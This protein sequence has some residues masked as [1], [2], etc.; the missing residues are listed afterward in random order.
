MDG[1]TAKLVNGTLTVRVPKVH[2]A[3]AGMRHISVE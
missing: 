1:V 3:T 2:A